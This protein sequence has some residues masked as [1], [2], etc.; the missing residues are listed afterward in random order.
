MTYIDSSHKA[1]SNYIYIMDTQLMYCVKDKDLTDCHQSD[2]MTYLPLANKAFLRI[3]YAN[4][5]N[6]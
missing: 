2:T 1:L 6:K 4:S 3:V 5:T